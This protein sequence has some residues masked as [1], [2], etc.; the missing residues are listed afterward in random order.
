M[1]TRKQMK[2]ICKKLIWNE[3][4]DKFNYYKRFSTPNKPYWKHN[5]DDLMIAPVATLHLL[6]AIAHTDVNFR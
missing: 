3:L 2:E 4:G 6:E 5:G 1:P